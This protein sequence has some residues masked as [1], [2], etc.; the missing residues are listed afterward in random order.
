MNLSEIGQFIKRLLV[1]ILLVGLVVVVPV[2]MLFLQHSHFQMGMVIGIAVIYIVVYLISIWLAFK[3]YQR[4]WHQPNGKLT[5]SDWKL[6]IVSLF[7]FFAVEIVIGIVAQLMHLPAGSENNQI[8]YQLLS[9]SPIVLVLMSVGMVFLTPMLEELV[10]RGF[11]I[12]GVLNWAPGWLAML[13]SGIVFSAGHASSNWLSFL[14]Y[15]TMGVILARV[16]LKTNRIQAS[17]TLHFL[18]NLFATIMMVISILGN[19]H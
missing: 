12:R 1:F 11:L 15:A 5:K 19:V 14:V 9:S 3:A 7:E 4:V 13:I 18:N 6:I 8:I 2:P 16:Y 17:M 10:F